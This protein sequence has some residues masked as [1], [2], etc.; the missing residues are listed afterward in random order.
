[1]V[2]WFDDKGFEQY[3]LSSAKA[4]NK[5]GLLIDFFGA[6]IDYWGPNGSLRTQ[7]RGWVKKAWKDP[8]CKKYMKER[9]VGW[10][11]T[12]ATIDG[13]FKKF[14]EWVKMTCK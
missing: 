7:T 10:K 8:K 14:S 5:N 9:L 1:M 4:K 6:W 2:D 12:P 13:I 11:Y 3:Y